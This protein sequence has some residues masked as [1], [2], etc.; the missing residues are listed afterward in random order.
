METKGFIGS[1]FNVQGQ[2]QGQHPRLAGLL[3]Q[4]DSAT[5]QINKSSTLAFGTNL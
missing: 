3:S 2:G 4:P 5:N 1:K